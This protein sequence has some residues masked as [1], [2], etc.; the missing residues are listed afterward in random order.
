MISAKDLNGAL[1]IMPTPA[2]EGADRLDAVN[3][4]DLDETARLTESLVRDGATGICSR[5]FAAAFRLLSAPPRLA[6]MRSRG[7]S[8]SSKSAAPRGRS[9]A[10]PC[11]NRLHSIWR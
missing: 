1:A 4:V 11:G 8:S 2:K 5:P 7:A 6:A 3:T 9:W 10:F